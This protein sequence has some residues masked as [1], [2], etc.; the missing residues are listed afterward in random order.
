MECVQSYNYLGTIIDSK[1]SQLGKRQKGVPVWG[2]HDDLILSCFHWI[3]FVFFFGVMVWKAIFKDQ[4]VSES[5]KYLLKWSNRLIGESQLSP[6]TLYT[7]QLQQITGPIL[8]MIPTLCT[9]RF[10]F[11]SSRR[12]SVLPNCRT[13][14]YKNSFV[15]QPTLRW[16]VLAILHSWSWSN[17][18]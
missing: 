10:S 16:T 7:R 9:A 13:K 12:G 8:M 1:L 2:S 3:D 17:V 4:K 5:N 11:F 15:L 18:Y 6:V 14:L